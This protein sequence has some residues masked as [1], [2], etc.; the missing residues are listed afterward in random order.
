[1]ASISAIASSTTGMCFVGSSAI[2]PLL[3]S[4]DFFWV[5]AIDTYVRQSGDESSKF[6][7][8]ISAVVA[9]HRNRFGA[10]NRVELFEK[11]TLKKRIRICHNAEV[12][13]I[14]H[15]LQKDAWLDTM[16]VKFVERK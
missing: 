3:Y 5:V 2:N 11:S 6:G 15:F 4:T 9:V 12:R 16:V 8:G 14:F 7:K 10:Y 1:M 13:I